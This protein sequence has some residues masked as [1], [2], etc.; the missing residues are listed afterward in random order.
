M[1]VRIDKDATIGISPILPTTKL[2]TNATIDTNA[3]LKPT[4]NTIV[5]TILNSFFENKAHTKQYSGTK[6]LK[7]S[8]EIQRNGTIAESVGI[9]KT[10]KSANIVKTTI[11]E[12][13]VWFCFRGKSVDYFSILSSSFAFS[14]I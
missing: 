11:N 4:L 5:S 3:R 6:M 8:Q 2:T 7:K 14:S 10:I 13:L 1:I 12:N 9:R